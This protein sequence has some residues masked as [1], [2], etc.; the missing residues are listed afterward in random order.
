MNKLLFLF[1]GIFLT[2]S[3]FSQEEGE[4][5]VEKKYTQ[6]EF[7]EALEKALNAKL[8]RFRPANIVTVSKEL[9]EK[10]KKLSLYEIKLKD[11]EEQLNLSERELSKKYRELQTQQNKLISCIDNNDRDK[12]KRIDHMV[13][14]VSGMRPATA[15]EV[16]SVQDVD[17]SVRI[18]DRLSATKVSKIFNSMDKEISARLQ[19]QYM[20]MKK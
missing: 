16:L 4:K 12:K 2:L 20:N 7:D 5:P 11:K 10:E 9:M 1:I 17:I 3:A 6:K 14:V 13:D 19:K 18:L 8:E 15:A